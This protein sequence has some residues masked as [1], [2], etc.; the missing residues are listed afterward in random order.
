MLGKR[1]QVSGQIGL[2]RWGH[3]EFR[4]QEVPNT[5]ATLLSLIPGVRVSVPRRFSIYAYAKL[6]LYQEP[7]GAQLLPRF[8]VITGISKSF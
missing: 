8:D 1:V 3:D 5:G 6:P 4:G 2:R 7:N